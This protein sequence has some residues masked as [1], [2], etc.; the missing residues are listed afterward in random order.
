[1]ELSV[2]A[3]LLV[4]TLLLKQNS[5][6]LSKCVTTLLEERAKCPPKA[7]ALGSTDLGQLHT[8]KLLP[9]FVAQ[10]QLA[11]LQQHSVTANP[12]ATTLTHARK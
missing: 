12:G 11:C 9:D 4:A 7:E 1:M 6:I 3:R 5:L 2:V 8:R 10:R